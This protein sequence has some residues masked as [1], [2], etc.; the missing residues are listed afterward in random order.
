V[1]ATGDHLAAADRAEYDHNVATARAQLDEATFAAAW[2]EGRR[3]TADATDDNWTQTVAYALEGTNHWR[4]V[5]RS[6]R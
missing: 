1:D 5:P 4:D 3:M 6:A 2:E